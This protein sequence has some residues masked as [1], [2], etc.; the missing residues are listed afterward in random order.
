MAEAAHAMKRKCFST[1][2]PQTSKILQ[3]TVLVVDRDGV[4]LVVSKTP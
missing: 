3:F 1:F 4:G 2:A